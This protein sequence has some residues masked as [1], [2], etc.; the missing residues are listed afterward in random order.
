MI[1]AGRE[2]EASHY[3]IVADLKTGLQLGEQVHLADF[4]YTVVGLTKNMVG[5]NADPVIYARLEDARN[6]LFER[7]PGSSA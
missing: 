1:V 2:I 7:G 3:E 6:I 4:D 5:F